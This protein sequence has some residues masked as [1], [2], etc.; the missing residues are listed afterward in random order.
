M[1]NPVKITDNAW[2]IE[3]LVA[4]EHGGE[5]S[6]IKVPFE[7]RLT[8]TLYRANDYSQKPGWR[9]KAPLLWPAVGRN[10]TECYLKRL[11]IG[12]ANPRL[13][14]Y[15]L[16]DRVYP[17]SIHGFAMS[18]P[19]QIIESSEDSLLCGLTSDEDTK[20]CYPF[21]FTLEVKY[22]LKGTK[23]IALYR[24]KSESQGLFFSIGN[25]ITFNLPLGGI[26]TYTD[27]LLRASSTKVSG[28]T[29]YAL[30]SGEETPRDF[31]D[32][33]LSDDSLLDMVT[34]GAGKDAFVEL[35]NPKLAEERKDP[36]TPYGLK[37][38]QRE[39]PT[40]GQIKASPEEFRFVFWGSPEEGYFCPE[41]WYGGPNSLNTKKGMIELDEGQEFLWEM[42][43][44]F[45]V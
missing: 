24:V 2:G 17:I 38:T 30:L 4:P 41:P 15:V 5:I 6:S 11:K 9:G 33:S 45:L 20:K 22:T 36:K 31:S 28:L 10:Y 19:W 44:E 3:V 7:G 34:G 25:H 39:V 14:E 29:P 43:I 13:G 21:D 16:G 12:E 23:I 18:K 42:G 40:S 37:I 8:E 26:G 1:N 27:T 32:V 35:I